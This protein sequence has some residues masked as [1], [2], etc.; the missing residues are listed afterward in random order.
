MNIR[1][2]A[3]ALIRRKL[4]GKYLILTSSE[5]EDNPSRS[6]K[7]DLPG[8]RVE[9]GETVEEGLRREL[10]EEIGTD[11]AGTELQLAYGSTYLNEEDDE[12][13]TF[14]VFFAEVEDLEVKLSW[15]HESYE[16]MTAEAVRSL[17]IREPYP[18]IFAH[19]ESAGLLG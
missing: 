5:W 12:S 13:V 17:E 16:W 18:A 15:E 6:Q 4:D 3:K 8:G 9:L 19:F 7:P 14:I 1:S 10:A 11:L 2:G